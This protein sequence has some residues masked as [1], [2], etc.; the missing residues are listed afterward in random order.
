MK[1]LALFFLLYFTP[2]NASTMELS[3]DFKY[4]NASPYMESFRDKNSSFDTSNIQNIPWQKMTTTNL[5]GMNNYYSWTKLKIKNISTKELKLILK[6]PRAGMD[7]IDVFIFRNGG[8][9]E[10]YA[11]GDNRNIN[12]RPLP[13]RYSV[14]PINLKSGEEI[15]LVTKLI[16]R[17]GGNDGEW[18]V[19]SYDK[20]FKFTI[21]ESSWWG[22]YVGIIL[23]LFIY[24]IPILFASKDKFL[25]AFF[26]IYVF[27]SLL[28][29]LS[30]NGILHSVGFSGEYINITT[31]LFGT[32]FGL[33]STLVLLRFF[34]MYNR[35]GIAL[36][37]IIAMTVLFCIEGIML[38]ALLFNPKLQLIT[39]QISTYVGI[40]GY[41]TWFALIREFF[42]VSKDRI[43]LY[44]FSGYTAVFGA[45]TFLILV[46]AGLIQNNVVSIYG[47]SVGSMIEM[48]FFTLAISE[49][50]SQMQKEIISK[51][52]LIGLQIRFASIGR[53]IG[54]I[55][56]QWKVPLVRVGTLMAQLEGTLCLKRDAIADELESI[57]P[58]MN[59]N[60]AFMQNTIDEFY[61][62]YKNES[63]MTRFKISDSINDA[64]NMLSG[65]A[66]LSN[67]N[68]FIKDGRDIEVEGYEHYLTH[69]FMILID[70]SIDVATSRFIKEPIVV[71]GIVKNIDNSIRI[72]LEDNCGGINQTPIESIFEIDV[73]SKNP[74]S[75]SGGLGLNIAKILVEEKMNGTITAENYSNGARF[76]LNIPCLEKTTTDYSK[77]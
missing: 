58:Q 35:K 33:F 16:N 55:S 12:D 25:A 24:A 32:M 21:I 17:I 6:N 19:Y 27:S 42:R 73:T 54:N 56:H 5:G 11:L 65:K 51:D 31:L 3:S 2:L 66:S 10:Q 18:D 47:V 26:S 67:V 43:F 23:A 30:V 75:A 38:V 48:L 9:S 13:H 60:L 8:L 62:L 61:S 63:K 72:I 57:L 69:T 77:T 39:A 20:F 41:F 46:S 36:W 4:S 50:I 70:N 44:I 29:Q 28:Y 53:V 14:V 52:K 45:Y 64:W 49:Y 40:I 1:I 7:E 76:I 68:I 34:I 71:F 22:L 15:E 37:T 59:S 74:S